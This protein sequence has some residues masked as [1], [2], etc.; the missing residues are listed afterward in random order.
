MRR[1][2]KWAALGAALALV[3]TATALLATAA[4]GSPQQ[5]RPIII[6]AAMDLTANMAPYD[7]PALYAVQA[8]IKEINA[9]GGIDG[10]R[11]R[12]IVCNH[13]LKNQKT[14]ALQ[15]IQKGAVIGMVTCDVEFAAPATQEFINKGMLALSPCIGTDQQGP[16]RFGLPRGRLAFTFGNIAQDEAAAMAE[17]AYARGWRRAV[18]VKDNLLAY[19]QNVADLFKARYQELG[20]QVVQEESFT[21]F[22]NTIQNAISKVAPT[23]ADVI[24][25]PT[26]FDGLAPFVGGLRQLGNSTPIINSWAGDGNYW[27]PQNPQVQNYYFVTYGSIYGDDPK[28]G[29]NRLVKQVTAVN[30]GTLPATGSFIPGADMIDGLVAAI[31]A[32]NG[33]TKG[34]VLATQL[35]KFKGFQATSGK[36]TFSKAVHGV[37]GRAYRVMFVNNNEAKF[38]RFWKTKKQAKL[39]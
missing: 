35:E 20:G 19:F 14:C 32:A 37:S 15:L 18:I 21:S 33:S 34:A 36:I 25:F 31:R 3:G 11:L 12:V 7:T 29:V 23:R 24:A 22:S 39:P 30:K 10:R 2:G 13:Q 27:W 26:A 28:S 16:K 8:R 38:L 6:G 17:Y 4:Q 5:R 9:A 1:P